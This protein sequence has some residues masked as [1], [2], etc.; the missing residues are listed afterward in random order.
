MATTD[1][2]TLKKISD[3]SLQFR[4]SYDELEEIVSICNKMV[5][6]GNS[7]S[8]TYKPVSAGS[9]S[10]IS[11]VFR[12]K[13]YRCRQTFSSFGFSGSLKCEPDNFSYYLSIANMV[14]ASNGFVQ[15]HVE[16]AEINPK[17]KSV[18]GP[19]LRISLYEPKDPAKAKLLKQAIES[20]KLV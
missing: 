8:I 7:A 2:S 6:R 20:I 13:I 11:R 14:I 1:V 4:K 16:K 5:L 3:F 9:K 19:V 17:E 18:P 10:N 12:V 15:F